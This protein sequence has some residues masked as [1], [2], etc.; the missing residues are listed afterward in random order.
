MEILI[1]SKS[2]GTTGGLRVS[3]IGLVFGLAVIVGSASAAA[4]WGYV[5]GGDAMLEVM[6]EDPER[7]AKIWQRELLQQRHFLND[8]ERD[9]DADL[10]ALSGIMGEMSG[11]LTRLDAAAENVMQ[12]AGLDPDEFAFDRPAPI[13]GPNP[14]YSKAPDWSEL[15]DNLTALS[16]E[17]ALRESRLTMLETFLRDRQS[18]EDARPGGVPLQDGWISS[19]YG[20]R[21]DPVSG[22]REF[23]TGIDFA[24]K[25]GLEVYAVAPGVVTWSGKRW[26]YGNL[27]EISHGSGYITRYAHNRVN[28]VSVGEKVDKNQPIA[29]LGMSGRT[30]GPHVH[31]EVVHDDKTINPAQF[32][33]RHAKR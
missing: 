23:H 2:R 5:Y 16:A 15:L 4:Y 29:L 6:L 9:L 11:S 17:I 10:G 19:G 25:P 20:Y 18:V 1:I 12:R 8:L 22:R 3:W 14:D 30:T 31:F 27:V 24:G 13:G 32:F 26:A 28:L 33:Q 7:S 21:T